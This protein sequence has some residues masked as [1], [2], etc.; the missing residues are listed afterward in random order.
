MEREGELPVPAAGDAVL[1]ATADA[2][3]WMGAL[4]V[5]SAGF[6]CALRVIRRV[7]RDPVRMTDGKAVPSSVWDGDDGLR[8]D[9]RYEA[10]GRAG[11]ISARRAAVEGGGRTPLAVQ[12]LSGSGS[13]VAWDAHLWV[14]PLPARGRVLLSG[15]WREA[16]V[17]GFRAE[18]DGAAIARA[19]AGVTR[20]WERSGPAGGGSGHGVLTVGA[21]DVPD[22]RADGGGGADG[23]AD[24][25][26]DGGADGGGG[27][28]R[29]RRGW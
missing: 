20:L 7:P 1:F 14:A 29:V 26:A 17:A 21:L 10:G 9:V 8:L 5:Y 13:A 6:V 12:Q 4:R 22:G 18:L 25:R 24:G 11:G 2:G 28:G 15:S 16:G 19:A 27:A 3:A 23:G